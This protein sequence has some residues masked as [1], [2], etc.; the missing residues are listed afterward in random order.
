MKS[1]AFV[2][3]L[4]T[5]SAAITPKP[6]NYDGYKVFRVPAVNEAAADTLRSIISNLGLSPWKMPMAAG[7]FSDIVVPPSQLKAFEPLVAAFNPEVMHEDLGK[8][9][10]A[11]GTYAPYAGKL[12]HFITL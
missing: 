6:V 11:E 7:A 4:A 1:A 12:T 8:S 3:L 10:A 5:A 9:I 2:S